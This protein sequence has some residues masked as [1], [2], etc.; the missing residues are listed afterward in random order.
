MRLRGS[1]KASACSGIDEKIHHALCENEKKNM[2]VRNN[3]PPLT[4]IFCRFFE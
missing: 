4:G 1:R 3:L 2:P